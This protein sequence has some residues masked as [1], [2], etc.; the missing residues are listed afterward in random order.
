MSTIQLQI[1]GQPFEIEMQDGVQVAIEDGRMTVKKSGN[2]PPVYPYWVPNPY[3]VPVVP[4]YPGITW[5]TGTITATSASPTGWTLAE[6]SD[7]KIN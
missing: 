4:Y 2:E 1:N 7:W 6:P 5:G 3:P